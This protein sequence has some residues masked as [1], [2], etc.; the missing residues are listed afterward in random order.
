[1]K[2]FKLFGSVNMNL[3][4]EQLKLSG[5]AKIGLGLIL[6][7]FLIEEFGGT[8]DF[9]SEYMVGSTFVFSF[10]AEAIF[11]KDQPSVKTKV[12]EIKGKEESPKFGNID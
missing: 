11:T 2:L 3:H 5:G 7:K 9:S 12:E 4:E 8:L 10:G 6:S 1:M